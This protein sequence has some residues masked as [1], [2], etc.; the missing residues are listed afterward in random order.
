MPAIDHERKRVEEVVTPYSESQFAIL[1]HIR[2]QGFT[3]CPEPLE[4]NGGKE[5]VS[6]VEGADLSHMSA[7]DKDRADE[8]LVNVCMQW[9]R[10]REA[11]DSFDHSVAEQLTL[12]STMHD[13]YIGSVPCH[14]DLN[15]GNVV[16]GPDGAINFIDFR[17]AALAEP[18][19][20]L[21]L[22]IRHWGPFAPPVDRGEEFQDLDSLNRFDL[23]CDEVGLSNFRRKGLAQALIKS[24]DKSLEMRGYTPAS[25]HE[26][27]RRA[28]RWGAD[29]LRSYLE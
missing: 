25:Y 7:E 20:D 9:K 14:L 12:P 23:V 19:Y 21:A 28:K 17:N 15:P 5:Y 2:N 26:K 22:L 11:C 8:L 16:L 3:N 24:Y 10:L 6:Y 29:V 13:D 18:Q 4:I 1:R 27:N